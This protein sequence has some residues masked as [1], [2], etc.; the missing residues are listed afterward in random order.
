MLDFGEEEVILLKTRT[1]KAKTK[2]QQE[3]LQKALDLWPVH[4]MSRILGIVRDKT[5]LSQSSGI[6]GLVSSGVEMSLLNIFIEF[7]CNHP[8][9]VDFVMKS[10]RQGRMNEITLHNRLAKDV[11]TLSFLER[12]PKSSGRGS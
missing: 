11:K 2:P 9:I 5:Q 8:T 6:V 12:C 7:T 3:K 1:M 10:F 4:T